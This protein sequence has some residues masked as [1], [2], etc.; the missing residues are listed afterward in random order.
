MNQEPIPRSRKIISK[1]L[2][3][4]QKITL[5]PHDDRILK[6]IYDYISGYA[7]RKQIE[8]A[9]ETIKKEV[10]TLNNAIPTQ[11]KLQMQLQRGG[12]FDYTVENVSQG[13][14]VIKSENDILLDKYYQAKAEQ[15]KLEDTLKL[16]SMTDHKISFKDLEGVLKSLNEPLNRKQIEVTLFKIVDNHVN[17]CSK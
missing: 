13:S 1:K 3:T 17:L 16:H 2:S 15:L 7:K 4:G 6:N 8:T 12:S 11:T 9:L 5:T 10:N 14:E